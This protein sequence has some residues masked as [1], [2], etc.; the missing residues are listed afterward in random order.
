VGVTL[1]EETPYPLVLLAVLSFGLVHA[2]SHVV[3]TAVSPFYRHL[4]RARQTAWNNRIVSIVHALVVAAGASRVL[5]LDPTVAH[6]FVYAYSP[7][8]TVYLA[9]FM[10]F[11][12]Y[13]LCVLTLRHLDPTALHVG[14]DMFLHHL[15]A[16]VIVS[17]P[18]LTKQLSHPSLL[19][20]INEWSTPLLHLRYFL[21]DFKVPKS[22]WVC[23]ANELA[24]ALVFFFCRVVLNTWITAWATYHF[25]LD[26]ETA[27]VRSPGD[28]VV[29]ILGPL[30]ASAF[31]LINIYWFIVIIRK[32]IESLRK[33]PALQANASHANGNS[34]KKT[35]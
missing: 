17:I 19:F 14:R 18:L 20:L 1:V 32:A 26:Q 34:S 12:V 35:D 8:G 21:S 30:L 10:A 9:C 2:A 31:A 22:H 24:F 29:A 15:V 27:Y 16:I 5:W 6:S 23:R 7:A 13:D 4:P 33:V 28:L 11:S 25:V 3:S